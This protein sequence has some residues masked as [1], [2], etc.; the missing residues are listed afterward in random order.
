MQTQATVRSPADLVEG[1]VSTPGQDPQQQNRQ[2]MSP[3]DLLELRQNAS[4]QRQRQGR[5]DLLPADLAEGMDD[6]QEQQQQSQQQQAQR[7]G[8]SQGVSM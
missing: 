8:Q 3:A 5:P 6:S 2:G 7:Q 4:L 1:R